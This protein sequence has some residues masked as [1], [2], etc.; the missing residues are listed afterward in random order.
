MPVTQKISVALGR[1]ELR[2][3][4]TAA[5]E[6]GVSLSAFLT[7]AV[8]K[9]LEE[10]ERLEAAREFLATFTRDELATPE[11][12]R[13]LLKFWNEAKPGINRDPVRRKRKR[14]ES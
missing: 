14:K 5:A 12:R 13:A 8:R 4:K 2:P 6:E 3:A 10:R 9:D 7:Q 1:T 11:E